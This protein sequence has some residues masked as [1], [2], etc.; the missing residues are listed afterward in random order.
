MIKLSNNIYEL[1]F[2]TNSHEKA[3]AIPLI[4]QLHDSFYSLWTFMWWILITES[5][6]FDI[7][8]VKH[9]NLL[10]EYAVFSLH[11]YFTITQL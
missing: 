7:L 2:Q 9:K 1:P 11:F 6:K 3:F 8:F 10:N 5:E 4:Q